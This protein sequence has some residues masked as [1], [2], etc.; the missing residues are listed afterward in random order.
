MVFAIE[1]G[2]RGFGDTAMMPT[3]GVYTNKDDGQHIFYWWKPPDDMLGH[4]INSVLN[5][6]NVNKLVSV[7]FSTGGDHGKGRFRHILTMALRFGDEASIVR[8]YV[9]G[10]IDSAKDSTTIMKETFMVDLNDRLLLL[11]S[12]DFVVTRGGEDGKMFGLQFSNSGVP[13]GA[14]IVKSVKSR[15]FVCGDTKFYMQILGREHAAP[16]WCVWSLRRIRLRNC[17]HSN[18]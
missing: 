13:V 15:I 5:E 16:H 11:A 3:I 8:R 6:G 1:K 2:V 4:E 14:R 7:D 9:I 12:G 17:G 18:R 10:E